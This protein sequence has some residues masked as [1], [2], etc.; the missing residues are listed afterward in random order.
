MFS[1]DGEFILT[2]EESAGDSEPPT[3][4]KIWDAKGRSV[5][6]LNHVN[7]VT[8]A[9]FRPDGRLI[10]TASADHTARIW[11]YDPLPEAAIQNGQIVATL[12]DNIR[13][14]EFTPDGSR[15]LTTAKDNSIK[16][17]PNPELYWR[18]CGVTQPKSRA[19]TSPKMARRSYRCRKTRLSASGTSRPA[20]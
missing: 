6:V 13:Q 19:S 18:R 17:K 1:P 14:V 10:L 8:C 15:V 20:A 11:R 9:Q 2:A 12:E 4:A 5:S 3:T 16:G 7:E